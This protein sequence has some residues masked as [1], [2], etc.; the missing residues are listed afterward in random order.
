MHILL[1]RLTSGSFNDEA[2]EGE[3][4]VGVDGSGEGSINGILSTPIAEK[5][6]SGTESLIRIERITTVDTLISLFEYWRTQS[7]VI[8]W[9]IINVRVA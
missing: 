9:S 7:T 8:A 6:D 1:I 3:A 5:V 2:Q 4:N